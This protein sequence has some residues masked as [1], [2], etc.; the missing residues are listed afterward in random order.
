MRHLAHSHGIPEWQYV[1]LRVYSW[2]HF[3]PILCSPLPIL[4]P[5]LSW[6]MIIRE[7]QFP[8]YRRHLQATLSEF[9]FWRESSGT[10]IPSNLRCIMFMQS[11][12][13]F[14][15][16]PRLQTTRSIEW[17]QSPVSI[18]W[19]HLLNPQCRQLW[20]QQNRNRRCN[21][22]N[23][24]FWVTNLLLLIIPSNAAASA[25]T[26]CSKSSRS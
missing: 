17:V 7:R 15:S 9:S 10:G 19:G 3:T 22:C 11:I 12:R 18:S 5:P 26:H 4:C 13:P 1:A 20:Q 16:L 14:S 25:F 24:C 2:K 6:V 21:S 23:G 8:H